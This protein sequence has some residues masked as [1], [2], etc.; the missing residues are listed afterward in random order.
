MS[1]RTVLLTLWLAVLAGTLYISAFHRDALQ[2][3]FLE[4][5]ASPPSWAYAAYLA[6]G[7]LRGFTLVPAT[8]LVLAGMLVLPPVSLFV[9]TI[10]GIIVSSTAVYYFAGAMQ[11]DRFFERRY[12]PQV[13][14]LRALMTRRELP[15]VVAWSFFPFAPT[16]LVCYVC[17]A[18]NVNLWKCLVGVT[19]GEGAICAVYIFLGGQGLGVAADRLVRLVV[20]VDEEDV[21]PPGRRLL[22]PQRRKQAGQQEQDPPRTLHDF[23]IPPEHGGGRAGCE[24]FPPCLRMPVYRLLSPGDRVPSL[25]AP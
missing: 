13:S 8:Y 4:L 12:S 16:D 19:I 14:R 10:A 21:G 3:L 17:G 24:G 7:C 6:A 15:I 1:H 2:R 20:G 23:H 9:L 11:L 18:L 22:R 5:S 25:E